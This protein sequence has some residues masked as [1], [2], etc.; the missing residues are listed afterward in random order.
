MS[1]EIL[2]DLTS[3][4][5]RHPWWHARARLML[6]LLER[7]SVAPPARVLDA[8]CGWGVNFEALER[9]GYQVEGLDISRQA[10][11]HLDRPG[12]SLIEADLTQPIP[13][14][15]QTY[16]AVVALDVI[17]HL[18]DD[19]AAV[20]RLTRLTKPGGVCILSVPALP[21]LYSEFD[22]VQGHRRR[23][24]PET[25][26]QACSESEVR[27]EQL[28]WWGSWMVPILRRRKSAPRSDPSLS[29]AQVYRRYLVLPSWPATLGLRFAFALDHAWT[30][31]GKASQGTSLFAIARREA[32]PIPSNPTSFGLSKLEA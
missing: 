20:S 14:R 21:E 27:I 11:E 23:Y 10:L 5:S 8:G 18:D 7:L 24:V 4:V 31:R 9:C 12:R 17:E 32:E 26:R 29:P 22:E 2:V 6:A 25:L 1:E 15:V 16:D 13:E 19:R 30:L 28:F 3:L